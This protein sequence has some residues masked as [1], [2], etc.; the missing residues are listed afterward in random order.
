M[1]F[2][3][4]F[5]KNDPDYLRKRAEEFGVLVRDIARVAS[6]SGPAGVSRTVQAMRAIFELGAKTVQSGTVEQLT[7][8]SALRQLFEALG[9]TYIKFGSS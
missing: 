2:M 1:P 4:D 7:A 5:D 9:A 6:S 3:E 8:P